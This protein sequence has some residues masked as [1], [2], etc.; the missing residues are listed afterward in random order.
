MVNEEIR[1]NQIFLKSKVK[2]YSPNQKT[3][4]IE[5]LGEGIVE[6]IKGKEIVFVDSYSKDKLI[7]DL[8]NVQS[9][10][11]KA[12]ENFEISKNMGIYKFVLENGQESV[13]WSIVVEQIYKEKLKSLS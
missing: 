7:F 11:Y 5:L 12:G 3:K 9:L 13:K 4:K 6:L 8:K 1:N 10:P 2:V